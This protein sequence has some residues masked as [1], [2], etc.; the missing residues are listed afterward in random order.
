MNILG[1]FEDVETP[2]STSLPFYRT[3]IKDLMERAGT[4]RLQE[5][6]DLQ[7]EDSRY[8]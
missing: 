4:W 2:A 5:G 7:Q 1:P 6:R 3:E 8:V